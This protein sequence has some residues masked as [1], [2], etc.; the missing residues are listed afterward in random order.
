MKAVQFSGIGG[1]YALCF[2]KAL[3]LRFRSLF[4]I[5]EFFLLFLFLF[6]LLLFFLLF[7]FLFFFL[8]VV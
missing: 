6:F 7:R 4:R 1:N 3:F 2:F 5:R 8:I